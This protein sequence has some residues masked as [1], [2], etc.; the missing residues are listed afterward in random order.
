MGMNLP[1]LFGIIITIGGFYYIGKSLQRRKVRW[2]DV[3]ATLNQYR[4]AFFLLPL[5]LAVLDFFFS[6]TFLFWLT[7]HGYLTSYESLM[8]VSL[9]SSQSNLLALGCKDFWFL[10]PEIGK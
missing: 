4:W 8:M 3:Y 5:V 9:F 2:S 10:I 1:R 7:F 6:R